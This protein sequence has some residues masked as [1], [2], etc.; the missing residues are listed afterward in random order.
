MGM[1]YVLLDQSLSVETTTIA[2]LDPTAYVL[3]TIVWSGMMTGMI[4]K[5]VQMYKIALTR[6]HAMLS[7]KM[8]NAS[9]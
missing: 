2:V 7:L 9:V 3:I 1:E 5:H 8:K 6:M 4:M